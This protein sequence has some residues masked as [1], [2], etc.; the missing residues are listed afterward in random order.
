MYLSSEVSELLKSKDTSSS[1]RSPAGRHIAVN[2]D[3]R[4]VQSPKGV[5]GVLMSSMGEGAAAVELRS[6]SA[7]SLENPTSTA[8]PRMQSVTQLSPTCRKIPRAAAHR[9][10]LGTGQTAAKGK[11]FLFFI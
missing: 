6:S 10:T 5:I 4:A 1:M 3:Q 7:H 8:G 2:R 9:R 11:L